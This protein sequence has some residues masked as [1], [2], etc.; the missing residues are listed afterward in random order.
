MRKM[1]TVRAAVHC[2]EIFFLVRYSEVD[3][4]Y[5]LNCESD[6]FFFLRK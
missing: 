1:R 2:K 4:S 5:G 3:A 6:F